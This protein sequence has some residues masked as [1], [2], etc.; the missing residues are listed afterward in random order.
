MPLAPKAVAKKSILLVRLA[1]FCVMVLPL[2]QRDVFQKPSLRYARL[3]SPLATGGG[4]A[5]TSGRDL[6]QKQVV[7]RNHFGL[8][9]VFSGASQ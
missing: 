7:S 8:V 6:G 5:V 1:L 3:V 2:I 9:T 4:T